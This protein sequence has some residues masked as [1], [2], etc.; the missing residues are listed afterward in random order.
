MELTVFIF[1][2]LFS[3][4]Q[5][6]CIFY[7]N[8]GKKTEHGRIS[9]KQADNVQGL[10]PLPAKGNVFHDKTKFQPV[11]SQKQLNNG[12]L[13]MHKKQKDPSLMTKWNHDPLMDHKQLV[14][15]IFK[16]DA[17]T[18]RA[19]FG[20]R[21]NLRNSA[22]HQEEKKPCK[23]PAGKLKSRQTCSPYICKSWKGVQQDSR[24]QQP[25][26]NI[27]QVSPISHSNQLINNN[28]ISEAAMQ[29][30]DF[31]S[32]GSDVKKPDIKKDLKSGPDPTQLSSV[33]LEL[34]EEV[35]FNNNIINVFFSHRF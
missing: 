18:G 14:L 32:A 4:V 23:S 24:L 6:P 17:F 1:L 26:E 13:E 31:C 9:R 35:R 20:H 8:K 21:E 11:N 29:F 33:L 5:R 15:M 27:K 28:S 19:S 3:Q 22:T 12:T 30:A 34:R 2:L 10:F 7:F 16:Q 25:K